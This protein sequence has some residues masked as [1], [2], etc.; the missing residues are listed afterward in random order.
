MFVLAG[1]KFKIEGEKFREFKYF[2]ENSLV[3]YTC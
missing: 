1:K 3:K 2:R